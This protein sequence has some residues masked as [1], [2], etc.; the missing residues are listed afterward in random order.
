MGKFPNLHLC[1]FK[2][3]PFDSLGLK[4]LSQAH[5]IPESVSLCD[6]RCNVIIFISFRYSVYNFTVLQVLQLQAQLANFMW[7][8]FKTEISATNTHC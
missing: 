1:T 2:L 5:L 3:P 6:G 8:Q 7:E 4:N